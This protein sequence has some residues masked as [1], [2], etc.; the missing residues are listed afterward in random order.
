MN[1]PNFYKIEVG[2]KSNDSPGNLIAER[3]RNFLKIPL[4]TCRIIHIYWINGLNS[5][6]A[7]FLI[8]N[9]IL[10]DPVLQSASLGNLPIQNLPDWFA[11]ISYRPGV[12][13]NEARTAREI[14]ALALNVDKENFT[15]N[16]GLEYRFFQDDKYPLKRKDIERICRELLCNELIQNFTAMDYKEWEKNTGSHVMESDIKMPE[17]KT[18]DLDA[19]D[20]KGLIKLSNEH[21][22]A[23]NLSEMRKI[24]SYFKT[25]CAK[26]KKTGLPDKPTDVEIEVIAQTWS[27]HCKHKIFSALINYNDLN[28]GRKL[29]INNLYKTYI[30]NITAIV[31]KQKGANDYCLSVFKDNAGVIKFIPGYDACIKVE[32]HNSP[33]AL[34]PYGGALTGIVGVNRDPM[35][36]GMGANLIANLDVFCFAPP[37]YEKVLPPRILH[38]GRILEGVRQGIEDG[39]NQSGIPTINGSL[40]FDDRFLGKPLVFCGTIGLLPDDIC[41]KP[42]YEKSAKIGDIIIMVGGRIG[43]DG[44]HGATFSSEE[45]HINSPITAVQIGDPITQRKMYDFIIRARDACLY[46]SITDNGAGGLSSSVGEMAEET[47]GCVI[48]LSKAPLKYPGLAAWEILLSEA[49]ER[50]TLAVPPDKLDDFLALAKQMDVEATP[51]GAFNDSGF[52]EIKYKDQA[53]GMLSMEFLHHGCPQMELNATWDS[54]PVNPSADNDFQKT[55]VTDVN[56]NDKNVDAYK[57]VSLDDFASYG[58]EWQND[59]INKMLRRFNICS[60]EKIIRQYDHEV[61][62]GSVIK[63]LTGIF[64]DGPTDAAV[65]RPM[66]EADAGLVIAHG[67]CPK[68]SDIDT[69]WMM[70][71]AMDEAIRNAVAVGANPDYL[72]GVDNFCWCDP[73]QSPKNPDGDYK[74][75]QLA[76]ACMALGQFALAYET[77]C[78][79]GKDSMKNDYVEGNLRISIPPTVLFTVLGVIDNVTR[80][81]TSDFKEAG[82]YIYLLGATWNEMGASE[83]ARELNLTNR[84]IP[85]VDAHSA[86]TRYRALYS[87]MQQRVVSACHDCSDGGIATALAEMCIGARLGCEI[88][89]NKIKTYGKINA[90]EIMYSESASRHIVTVKPALAPLLDALGMWQLCAHIGFVTAEPT[91]KINSGDSQIMAASIDDLAVSFKSG[92]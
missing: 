69:Y 72:A 79:S 46:N 36:T 33:S 57:K 83:A 26:R 25:I 55:D 77:P 40:V 23:L 52:F 74:L 11:E 6:Q 7:E 34:D 58:L 22:W 56:N 62:G 80:T 9:N 47:G 3:I 43:K 86:L 48:D 41:G 73:I 4:K 81:Q 1:A 49:Q 92:L 61:G 60:K 88:D 89:I 5:E 27:E 59:F 51:L 19:L 30:R 12:T 64:Q 78:I 71:N 76:K 90:F 31:R 21:T 68:Y 67:I 10:S 20:D 85:H 82:D 13:D 45:L 87:L 18:Y 16:S 35:G 24:K 66:L 75:A 53:V 42:G 54:R 91:L 37:N 50:M 28:T 44:I 63:P 15:V 14:I 84:N 32:T 17:V 2:S 65:F 8:K 70:A 39:G 29:I 38:P